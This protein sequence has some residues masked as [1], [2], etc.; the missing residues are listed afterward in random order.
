[1]QR[2]LVCQGQGWHI[3]YFTQL[4]NADVIKVFDTLGSS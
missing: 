3:I 4:V 2:Q 1:V